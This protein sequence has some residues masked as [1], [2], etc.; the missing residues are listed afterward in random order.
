MQRLYLACRFA[1]EHTHRT[2]SNLTLLQVFLASR[3]V[4]A[5]LFT[6]LIT[7]SYSNW[8]NCERRQYLEQLYFLSDQLGWLFD[9]SNKLF[10]Q[11]LYIFV[12]TSLSGELAFQQQPVFMFEEPDELSILVS[13]VNTE[14]FAVVGLIEVL[15]YH[16]TWCSG[17]GFHYLV[18]EL[19]EILNWN[20]LAI[21]EAVIFVAQ[22][23][24][25]VVYFVFLFYIH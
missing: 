19:P 18:K 16:S 25:I 7:R 8:V 20:C 10:V 22:K 15:S 13:W 6:L 24:E 1:L 21:F 12:K 2:H 17:K 9:Y 11:L 23:F 3:V 4:V 14:I 5:V